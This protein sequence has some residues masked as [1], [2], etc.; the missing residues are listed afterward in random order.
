MATAR[1]T[2]LNAWVQDANNQ[3][4]QFTFGRIL[5]TGWQQMVAVLDVSRGWPNQ[6]V[7]GTPTT[8]A[9][10][11]PLRFYALVLDGYPED[12]PLQGAIYVDDLFAGNAA[13]ITPTPT[14][15]PTPTAARQQRRQQRRQPAP[16]FPFAPIARASMPGS[17]PPCAGMSTTLLGS[18]STAKE[19][20]GMRAARF[21]LQ[22]H[23]PTL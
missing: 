9:P 12:T 21:V 20:V 7:G 16:V 22:Q 2:I 15:A 5:H 8:A 6:A 18:T 1:A 10:V 17:A 14:T 13:V 23:K 3:L 4:W 11:Y 19:S